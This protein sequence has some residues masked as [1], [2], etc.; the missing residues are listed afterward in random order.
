MEEYEFSVSIFELGKRGY[1]Y[2]VAQSIKDHDG[3][4]W[5]ETLERGVMDTW[6]EAAQEAGEAVKRLLLSVFN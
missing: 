4:D 1:A 5:D 2:V 6:A 3:E